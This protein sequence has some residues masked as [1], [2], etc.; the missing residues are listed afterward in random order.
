MI[1]KKDFCPYANC[2]YLTME[3]SYYSDEWG[4]TWM[5]HVVPEWFNYETSN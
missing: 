5:F 4:D 1:V 3:G 2:R